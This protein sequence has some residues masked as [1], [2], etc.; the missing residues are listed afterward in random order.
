MSRWREVAEES[1]HRIDIEILD[2][3]VGS[4]L[5]SVF[6]LWHWCLIDD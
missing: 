4:L 3:L 6:V 5:L 1:D 2:G